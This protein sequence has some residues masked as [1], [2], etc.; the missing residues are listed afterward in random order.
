LRGS[1]RFLQFLGETIDV[2]ALSSRE[3]PGLQ[4]RRSAKTHG[5]QGTAMPRQRRGGMTCVFN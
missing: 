1:D 3:A 2:H 5:P 4:A